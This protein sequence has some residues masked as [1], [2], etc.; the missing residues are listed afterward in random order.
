M[1]D[2]CLLPDLNIV[3]I[4]GLGQPKLHTSTSQAPASPPPCPLLFTDSRPPDFL[5]G[6]LNLFKLSLSI[7]PSTYPNLPLIPFYGLPLLPMTVVL[8]SETGS[9][10][11]STSFLRL[12][13]L[14]IPPCHRSLK[15]YY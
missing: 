6:L 1:L 10:L 8:F 7:I 14:R 2:E 4:R 12:Q 9:Y 11:S 13:L 15:W 5:T 3:K